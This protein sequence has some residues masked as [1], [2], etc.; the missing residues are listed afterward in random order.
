MSHYRWILGVLLLP[1][2]GCS[3]GAVPTPEPLAQ[4]LRADPIHEP[5]TW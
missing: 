5:S 3:F 1:L 4:Q 2:V